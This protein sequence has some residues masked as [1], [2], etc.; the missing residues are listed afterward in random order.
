MEHLLCILLLPVFDDEDVWP[1]ALI[2]FKDR[3]VIIPLMFLDEK[4]ELRGWVR[5]IFK[6][7]DLLETYI[8]LVFL[9]AFTV[10]YFIII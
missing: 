1:M 5:T 10:F 9:I 3:F 6:T 2:E 7:T 4:E 8:G